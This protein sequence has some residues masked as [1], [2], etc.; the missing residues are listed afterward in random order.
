MFIFLAVG[1][2]SDQMC[3]INCH[4]YEHIFVKNGY[5]SPNF[6]EVWT[7]CTPQWLRL[8]IWPHKRFASFIFKGTYNPGLSGK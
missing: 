2:I 4:I 5:V 8:C 3:L 6:G 1:I 7:P